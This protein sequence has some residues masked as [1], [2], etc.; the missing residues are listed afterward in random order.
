[1]SDA[2]VLADKVN[3]QSHDDHAGDDADASKL[4]FIVIYG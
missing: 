3:A 4:I 1:M 2:V